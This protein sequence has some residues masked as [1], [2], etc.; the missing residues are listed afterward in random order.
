M[1]IRLS[2]WLVLADNLDYYGRIWRISK[3]EREK[4]IRALLEPL[5]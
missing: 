1:C 5:D 4:R 2:S 3:A